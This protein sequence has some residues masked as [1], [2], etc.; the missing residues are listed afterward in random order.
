MQDFAR[1]TN[2]SETT[3]LL[4]P[5]D[6]QADY[7]VRIFTPD[8]E[9][10]FR[11]PPDARQ[12]Q[13]LAGRRRATAPCRR[14]GA[15]VRCRPGAGAAHG[16]APGLR[17]AAARAQRARSTRPRSHTSPRA[18]RVERGAIRA[19]QWVDNGPGWVAV[20]LGSR[21]DAVL[22]LK[23]RFRRHEAARDGR[24]G[25]R[26]RQGYDAQFEVRAFIPGIG[27]SED[28]VTGSLNASLGSGSSAPAWRPRA[29]WPRKA[30]RLAAPGACMSNRSMGRSGSAATA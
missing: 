2:F 1:W 22:A 14:R 29:T 9:L 16:P 30:R 12:L 10:P 5:T 7:R 21:H 4:P 11:R 27:P 15:A 24:G 26:V 19:S 25:A 17:G 3:F 18:L 23:P 13:R 20:M 6:P 8:R 28:P